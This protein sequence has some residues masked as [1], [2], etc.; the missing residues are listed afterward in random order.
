MQIYDDNDDDVLFTPDNETQ[1]INDS[2]HM[3]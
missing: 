1:H 3:K 2:V